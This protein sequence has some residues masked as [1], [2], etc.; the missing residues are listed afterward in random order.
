MSQYE[1]MRTEDIVYNTYKPLG[2]R[3]FWL[4][5]SKHGKT[6]PKCT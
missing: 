5:S 6:R 4:Q 1:N 3:Y 2:D